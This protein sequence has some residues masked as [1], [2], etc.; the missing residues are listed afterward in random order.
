[1]SIK[2]LI[3]QKGHLSTVG[4]AFLCNDFAKEDGAIVK[5][6]LQAGA[7]PI[8]R[9]NVPQSALSLHTD[10]LIWGEAKNPHDT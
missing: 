6:F 4:T 9:G 2:D 5:C 7:I 1:M 8:V 10:N 3:N